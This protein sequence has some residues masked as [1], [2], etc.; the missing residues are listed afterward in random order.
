M[1]EWQPIKT[2]P[3]DGTLIWFYTEDEIQGICYLHSQWSWRKF[4]V[5]KTWDV[6][7][8]NK[9]IPEGGTKPLTHWMPLPEKPAAKTS[10]KKAA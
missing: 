5:E 1:L 7:W 6:V 8:N 9:E 4:K 3:Q 2:A 10:S